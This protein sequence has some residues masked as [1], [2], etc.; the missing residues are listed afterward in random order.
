[1]KNNN[2]L[3]SS[4]VV[5]NRQQLSE[6]LDNLQNKNMIRVALA[7]NQ[8]I[9]PTTI[10]NE[11]IIVPMSQKMFSVGSKFAFDSATHTVTIL[12]GVKKIKISANCNFF[13]NAFGVFGIIVFKNNQSIALSYGYYEDNFY[14]SFSIPSICIDVNTN[15]VIKMMFYMSE[16][17]CDV[18][19]LSYDGGG[20][21]LTIE[22][23]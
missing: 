2:Y 23:I 16:K 13:N 10:M 19:L 7:E 9:G 3:D 4:N 12:D 15:D 18:D 5:H 11:Q 8:K 6:I 1:M 17:N 20:T 14:H 21:Y 22:E